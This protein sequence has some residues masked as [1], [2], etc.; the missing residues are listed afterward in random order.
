[1]WIGGMRKSIL[2]QFSNQSKYR[3]AFVGNRNL[4]LRSNFGQMFFQKKKSLYDVLEVDPNADLKAIKKAFMKK[5]IST[6]HS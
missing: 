4:R 2:G 6:S 5:G 1:M 3:L